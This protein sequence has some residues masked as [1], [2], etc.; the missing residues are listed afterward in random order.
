MMPDGSRPGEGGNTIISGHRFKYLPP[1]NLTFYLFHKLKKDDLVYMLWKGDKI[2]YKIKE[3]KVVEDTD[4]SILDQTDDE[5]L[6]MFT[7]TPIYST[8]KRLVIIAE[9][10]DL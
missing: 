5:I 1:N 2:F 6:T 4:L 7:C 9:P 10:V 3:I 8:E